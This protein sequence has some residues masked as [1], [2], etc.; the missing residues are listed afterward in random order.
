MILKDKTIIK[1][2]RG[3]GKDI[4]KQVGKQILSGKLN[5]TRV[6]FPIRAMIPKSVLE[7]SIHGSKI[8]EE[9]FIKNYNF[10]IGSTIVF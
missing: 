6:S 9:N 4:I 7:S 2:S 5:L 3:I 10:N 8:I 1:K